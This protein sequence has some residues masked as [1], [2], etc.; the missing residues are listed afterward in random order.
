M[1]GVTVTLG[2]KRM[3]LKCKHAFRYDNIK[4]YGKILHPK[5]GSKAKSFY[6]LVFASYFFIACW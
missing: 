3:Q 6:S 5:K 4:L 2:R 1:Y